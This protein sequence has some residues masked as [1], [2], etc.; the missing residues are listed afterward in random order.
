M[1][2]MYN[3][4]LV[5]LIIDHVQLHN[6]FWVIIS[7]LHLKMSAVTKNHGLIT[8]TSKLDVRL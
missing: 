1:I 6:F 2:Y 4:I 3:Y 7:L 5:L 8:K